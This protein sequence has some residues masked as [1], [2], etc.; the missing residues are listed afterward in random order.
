MLVLY[1]VSDLHFVNNFSPIVKKN[2]F[3]RKPLFLV[4]L[5]CVFV[6]MAAAGVC[7]FPGGTSPLF[8]RE[9]PSPTRKLKSV[10]IP[11]LVPRFAMSVDRVPANSVTAEKGRAAE[12]KRDEGSGTVEKQNLWEAKEKQRQSGWMEYLE[13]AKELIE[14]DG[15]PPR[16][17]S[18]LES[19]SR[20][21]NSPVMLFLPGES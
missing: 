12:A 6:T 1:S 5:L 10:R 3:S 21:D 11:S 19:G 17:F 14:P 2:N 8:R 15:G 9:A 13:Q 16:W 4:S 18:P 7:F 20:L